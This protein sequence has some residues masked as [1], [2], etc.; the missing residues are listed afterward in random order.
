LR[1][2]LQRHDGPR[3]SI[4]TPRRPSRWLLI[5]CLAAAACVGS[6]SEATAAALD[7]CAVSADGALCDDQQPCTLADH[8]VAHRC[9]GTPVADGTA[10]T[11]GNLCTT[12]DTC[13]GAVCVGAQAA[14]GTA[15]DDADPCTDS[16]S[17]RAGRCQPG[18]PKVCDDGDVCTIDQCVAGMGCLFSPRDC[19]APPDAATDGRPDA[20]PDGAS[21]DAAGLDAPADAAGLDGPADAAG[22]DAPADA[23]GDGPPDAAAD[24]VVTPPDLRARGGACT[25]DATPGP[26][27]LAGLGAA[28]LAA[29]ILRRRRPQPRP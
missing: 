8:C 25:C 24:G 19:Q 1:S 10:C 16:D 6:V 17:C 21:A 4:A 5:G 23:A 18:P 28:F 26:P 27:S 22:F 14:D 15:C 20:G 29:F 2:S 12:G 9:V 13:Q 7:V 11:D 3:T